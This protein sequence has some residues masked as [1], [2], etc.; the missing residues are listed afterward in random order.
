MNLVF[1]KYD[2]YI[3]FYLYYGNN[4]QCPSSY[5]AQSSYLLYIASFIY[6]T[7]LVPLLAMGLYLTSVLSAYFT[8]QIEAELFLAN[9]YILTFLINTFSFVTFRSLRLCTCVILQ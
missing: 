4:I 9:V 2:D 1:I 8:A 6:Y 3:L 7:L 5:H